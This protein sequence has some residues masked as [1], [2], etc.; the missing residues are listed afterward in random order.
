MEDNN[1]KTK[2]KSRVSK[3]TI[4]YFVIV[5]VLA[6]AFSMAFGVYFHVHTNGSKVL[7]RVECVDDMD[8][9]VNAIINYEPADE[10]STPT[11]KPT[12]EVIKDGDTITYDYHNG[13]KK[14]ET[15]SLSSRVQQFC[16]SVVNGIGMTTFAIGVIVFFLIK[17]IRKKNR[18]GTIA[19]SVVLALALVFCVIAG[20]K[21]NNKMNDEEFLRQKDGVG[22]MHIDAPI[23]YLYDENEREVSVKLDFEGDLTCTYPSYEENGGWTVKTSADGTLTDR[24]GRSYEYLFFEADLGFTPDTKQG[25][26]VKGEDTAAFLE[27]ALAE[28]G[29]TEKEANTFIMYWLPQMEKNPYNV[30]CFQKDA[31]ENS[32]GLDVQPAPDTIIRVNMYFYPSDEYTYIDEQDLSSMN[33]SVEERK[34]LVLVEWGGEEGE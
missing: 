18:I 4:L 11:T 34:G 10:T 8:G 12:P 21:I 25:F 2:K 13:F 24:N 27:G 15:Y 16:N 19:G 6:V 14:I 1:S 33:P 17:F 31:Y 28:L 32:V 23:I 7:T 9:I 26:C 3:S 5:L 30:I 20:I 22:V 29:L